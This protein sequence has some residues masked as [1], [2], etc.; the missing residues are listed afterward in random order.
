MPIA[1]FIPSEAAF[2]HL[3]LPWRAQMRSQNKKIKQISQFDR[4]QLGFLRGKDF[5]DCRE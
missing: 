2:D 1:G 4:L 5:L 3:G